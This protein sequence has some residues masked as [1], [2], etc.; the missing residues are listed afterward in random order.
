[1]APLRLVELKP[2]IIIKIDKKV[3]LPVKEI[4]FFSCI[5]CRKRN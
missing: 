1:M 2:E 5:Q 3:A 4:Y